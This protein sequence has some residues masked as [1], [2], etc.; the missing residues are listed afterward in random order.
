MTKADT[1]KFESDPP[2]HHSDNQVYFC[3]FPRDGKPC[4]RKYHHR[5]CKTPPKGTVAGR[6]GYCHACVKTRMAR[7]RR[8]RP[9][10]LTEQE[11]IDAIYL[12]YP[13]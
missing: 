11:I 13:S 6:I 8:N 3:M 4:G 9:Q 10:H 7:L 2:P 5:R 1:L 12:R